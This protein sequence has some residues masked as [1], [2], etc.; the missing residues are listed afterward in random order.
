MI[1]KKFRIWNPRYKE[2][3][4]WGFSE[5]GFFQG[6]PTGAGLTIEYCEKNSQQFTD[7]PA[8][9]G[10]YVCEGDIVKAESKEFSDIVLGPVRYSCGE[11]VVDNYHDKKWPCVS[12]TVLWHFEIIGN[13]HENPELLKKE[14]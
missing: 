2:F 6:I 5:K 3:R 11:Y 14:Q 9:N 1:P 8:K 12:V 4:Y 10:L 7:I 13:T